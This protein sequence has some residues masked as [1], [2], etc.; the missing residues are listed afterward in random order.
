LHC[1]QRIGICH[2]GSF[3]YLW[4]GQDW[5]FFFLMAVIA[6]AWGLAGE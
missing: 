3:I 6:L 1:L 4:P 2:F 5:S